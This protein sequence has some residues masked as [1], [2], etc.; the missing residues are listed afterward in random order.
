MIGPLLGHVERDDDENDG[1]LRFELSTILRQVMRNSNHWA[2]LS[3]DAVMAFQSRYSLRL[4]ELVS[5]RIGRQHQHSETFTIDDL[6]AL[7]G[8]PSGK[9][10]TWSNLRMFV[11]EKAIAEV[12]HLTG[13]AVTYEPVKRGRSVT[14]IKLVWREKEQ[15][16]R[17]EAARELDRSSIGRAARRD[18]TAEA[19]SIGSDTMAT[20]EDFRKLTKSLAEKSRPS[21]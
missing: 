2:A 13:L 5:L 3:R 6:R 15:S 14:G 18:G 17:D 19:V 21:Y 9:L 16:E 12:S 10:T 1:E 8:V 4:Y 20:A 11:I 7:F